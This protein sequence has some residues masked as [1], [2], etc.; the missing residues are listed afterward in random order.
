MKTKIIIVLAIYLPFFAAL[1]IGAFMFWDWI[2]PD[3]WLMPE[4]FLAF[5]ATAITVIFIQSVFIKIL[6]AYQRKVKNGK[7]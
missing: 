6:E 4:G 7:R 3:I 5:I 2:I 1:N